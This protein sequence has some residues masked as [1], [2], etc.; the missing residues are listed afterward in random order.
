MAF[1][2]FFAFAGFTISGEEGL[3]SLYQLK[4]T[5]SELIEKN[6]ELIKENLAHRQEQK[7]LY[8]LKTI[9]HKAHQ[10]LG[11][12]YPDETVYIINPVR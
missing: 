4:K 10:S 1:V 11:L 3:V 5:K 8:Q 6:T 9:E 2:I 12:V 7:S